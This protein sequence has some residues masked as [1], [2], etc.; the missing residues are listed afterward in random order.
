[1][2]KYTTAD[3]AADVQRLVGEPVEARVKAITPYLER[4]LKDPD[5]TAEQRAPCDGGA[6]GHLLH[7]ADDGSFFIISVVFPPGT[8]SGVH[9][10]GAWGVIGILSG[11]DEETQYVR[12]KGR[13]EPSAG[14]PCALQPTAK[15]RYP[16]SITYLLPP[17]QGYHR[18]RAVGALIVQED[19]GGPAQTVVFIARAACSGKMGILH[20]T[21]DGHLAGDPPLGSCPER[22]P[23]STPGSRSSMYPWDRAC[24][25]CSA[26]LDR[27]EERLI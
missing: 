17:Q 4:W 9:Y 21:R 2:A 1:M 8:S 19:E 11:I 14:E 6:C 20:P 24:T 15:H 12:P 22:G 3:L 16:G 27:R 7:T 25:V 10:H 5:L 18:V 13:D 23:G 26:R